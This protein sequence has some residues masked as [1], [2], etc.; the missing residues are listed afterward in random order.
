MVV[1]YAGVDLA[2]L[3]LRI[4]AIDGLY[5]G[6]IPRGAN[7]LLPYQPGRLHTA[8][9]YDDRHV[10]LSGVL[11]G[12]VTRRALETRLDTLVGLFPIGSGEQRLEVTRADGA[13]RYI[14][15][16]PVSVMTPGDSKTARGG[17]FSIEFVAS[18]PFWYGS[19]L[20]GGGGTGAWT[21]DSGVLLDDGVHYLDDI[22]ALYAQSLTARVTVINA[23]NSG[24]AANRKPI[25][26]L[27]GSMISPKITNLTN[28]YSV[29]VTGLPLSGSSTLGMT[30][31][32]QLVIDCGDRTVN[33]GGVLPQSSITIG[34]G[35][36][37]WMRLEPGENVLQIDLGVTASP[38][39]YQVSYSPTYL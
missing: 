17:R 18:D 5:G 30:F 39:A 7:V 3:G 14:M 22:G 16:E 34:A 2:S 6:P 24:T 23:H 33:I 10:V 36:T 9:Y 32:G 21:L 19:A 11:S 1:K 13:A 26:T 31:N 27:T 35:Q 8:K 25:F 4:Q 12:N 15:A 29:Q 28:G 38:V 37:D 20:Q